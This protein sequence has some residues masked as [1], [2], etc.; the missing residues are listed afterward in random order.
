MKG[1]DILTCRT[2]FVNKYPSIIQTTSYNFSGTDTTPET[3]VGI[4]K[5]SGTYQTNLAQHATDLQ[6]LSEMDK[7][8]HVFKNMSTNDFKLIDCILY[9]CRW[10]M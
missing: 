8:K 1:K 3:C 10:G 4:V 5:A 6:M 9:T 2:D 7:C